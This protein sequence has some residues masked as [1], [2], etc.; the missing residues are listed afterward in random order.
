METVPCS[1]FLLK[2]G[3]GVALCGRISKW[4]VERGFLFLPC[5]PFV[6]WGWGSDRIIL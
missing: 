2:D 3:L 6:T 4:E 5:F 1:I